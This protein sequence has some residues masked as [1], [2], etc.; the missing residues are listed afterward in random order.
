[1]ISMNVKSL[2]LIIISCR[3]YNDHENVKK[4]EENPHETLGYNSKNIANEN[5]QIYSLLNNI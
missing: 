1:M 3:E 4:N 5:I 2:P